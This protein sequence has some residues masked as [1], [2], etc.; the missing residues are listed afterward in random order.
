[1]TECEIEMRNVEH[2]K[3]IMDIG[4][5]LGMGITMRAEEFKENFIKKIDK[6]EL[7]QKN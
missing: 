4:Y 6:E 1:M 2:L 5:N 7:C 3:T